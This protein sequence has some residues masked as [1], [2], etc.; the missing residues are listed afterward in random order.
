MI[1]S[2]VLPVDKGSLTGHAPNRWG[3]SPGF[4][5]GAGVGGDGAPVNAEM[6][7][8][9]AGIAATIACKSATQLI[10][11]SFAWV[12]AGIVPAYAREP[13]AWVATENS[14]DASG[15]VCTYESGRPR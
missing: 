13:S 14:G 3:G 8:R 5:V 15:M 11:V 1:C 2:G 6:I 4:G 12:P 9:I 10:A 7:A